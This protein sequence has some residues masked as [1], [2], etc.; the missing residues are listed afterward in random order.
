M[1][2]PIQ[3][4]TFT[5]DT[6]DE[7]WFDE[8]PKAASLLRHA[9][10]SDWGI[11][12]CVGPSTE[13]DGVWVPHTWSTADFVSAEAV[14]VVVLKLDRM[15]A[16]YPGTFNER[17]KREDTWFRVRCCVPGLGEDW[18]KPVFAAA[19]CYLNQHAI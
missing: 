1:K 2:A 12:L 7:V 13:S 16:E 10:P 17:P 6:S 3:T 18:T 9:L 8:H 11:E 4:K 19:A 14:W 15:E 5:P